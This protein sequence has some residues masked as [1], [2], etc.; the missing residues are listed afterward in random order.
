MTTGAGVIFD[1]DGVIVDSEELQYLSY[2][3]VLARYGAAVTREEYER[4]WIA[5]GLGPEY[6]VRCFALPIGPDELRKVKEPI[7][8]EMLRTRAQLIPGAAAAIERLARDMPLAVATNSTAADLALVLDPFDLRRYFA[9]V[10][11]REDYSGR[12]PAPDAFLTAALRLAMPPASCVVIED[13]TKGVLAAERAGCPC[14]AIPNDFTRRN[15]FTRASVVLEHFGDVTTD[16][17]R[18]LIENH[19]AGKAAVTGEGRT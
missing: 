15:D 2:S 9:A 13:A 6:A 12:K 5:A 10:V 1:F 19:H 18:N 4:E 7:Y 17:V 8:H 14:I 16:L 3:E 11:S